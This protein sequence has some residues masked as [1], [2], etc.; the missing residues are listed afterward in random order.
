MTVDSVE[1]CASIGLDMRIA[2]TD[3]DQALRSASAP[4]GDARI[5]SGLVVEHQRI[6]ARGL[7]AGA[8]M[9]CDPVIAQEKQGRPFSIVA[10]RRIRI[11][12]PPVLDLLA[13][14]RRRSSFE[15]WKR[16]LPRSTGLEPGALGDCN[17]TELASSGTG[18]SYVYLG[19]GNVEPWVDFEATE[20]A[21]FDGKR[22]ND[23]HGTRVPNE[24]AGDSRRILREGARR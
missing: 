1:L 24:A 18:K 21:R 4:S 12:S 17:L 20:A 5:S 7:Y 10:M 16:L 6:L 13:K 23:L 3:H 9:E 15:E 8:T 22:W 19:G 11:A 2:C 14:E